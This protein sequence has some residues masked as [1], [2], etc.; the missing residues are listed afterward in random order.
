MTLKRGQSVM[1]TAVLI[2]V[3]VGALIAMQVYLKR[4]IQGRLRSGV[5]SIGEQYDPQ[6]TSSSFTINHMSNATTTTNTST[7][8]KT[9]SGGYIV[10]PGGTWTGEPPVRTN[11]TTTDTRIETHYDNTIRNGY[12]TVANP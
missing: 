6:A 7:Q 4:G 10:F 5:D 11:V 8:E 9:V 3:I 1:E 2:L 12:E